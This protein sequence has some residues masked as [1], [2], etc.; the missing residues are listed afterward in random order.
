MN[1]VLNVYGC[2]VNEFGYELYV[3]H[4]FDFFRTA[5]II[6][7][8]LNLREMDILF[9]Y[10]LILNGIAFILIGYDKHLAKTQ[11]QRISERNLL[12]FVFFGGT[13]GSGLAMLAF[14]HKTAKKSYLLKFWVIVIFQILISWF[15][16]NK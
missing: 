10:F 6:S 14:R 16:L 2:C 4:F 7:L 8:K 5:K 3:G 12:G 1:C 15:Y 9:Y 11:K 13:I